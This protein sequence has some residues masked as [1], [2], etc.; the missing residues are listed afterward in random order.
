[1]FV[2]HGHEVTQRP[3]VVLFVTGARR[4][5]FFLAGCALHVI[6]LAL[7]LI[8]HARVVRKLEAIPAKLLLDRQHGVGC[9]VLDAGHVRLAIAVPQSGRAADELGTRGRPTDHRRREARGGARRWSVGRCHDEQPLHRT[10][11]DAGDL[12]T[13]RARRPDLSQPK[14]R[15]RREA[16]ALCVGADA[17]VHQLIAL[18]APARREA[19]DRAS[20]LGRITILVLARAATAVL[21]A[22]PKA[23]GYKAL[24]LRP[25]FDDSAARDSA[26]AVSVVLRALFSGV[27]QLAPSRLIVHQAAFPKYVAVT[28]RNVTV[29]GRPLIRLGALNLCIEHL[30]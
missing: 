29:T 14:E 21:E 24:L 25:A 27:E 28:F 18:A 17:R 5:A 4:A 26:E 11:V 19:H 30:K 8:Q 15:V 22:V 16:D 12:C 1:M 3:A 7:Q 20:A 2:G 23:F 9:D 6:I 10:H 13:P